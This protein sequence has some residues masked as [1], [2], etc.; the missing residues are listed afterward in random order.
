MD[1]FIDELVD[2]DELKWLNWCRLHLHVT[3]LS[4]LTTADGRSLTAAALRGEPSGH[5]KEA[6]NWPRTRR[7]GPSHWALWRS[8]L[9]QAVLRPYS[10]RR[11]LL[12]P[13]GQ[14]TDSLDRWNWLLSRTESILFHRTSDTWELFRPINARS[15]RTFRKGPHQ[16][17]T[18]ALPNDVQRTS[19]ELHPRTGYVTVTGTGTSPTSN[20]GILHIWRDLAEE[21]DDDFGWVP[22]Y[23]SIEG[24]E[25]VLLDALEKGKLRMVSD[26]SFKQQVG[27]AAVQLRTRRGGH[28]IWIKCRTPGKREDQSAYR[29]E[30]IGLLAGILVTSWLRLRLQT[31]KKPRVRVACDGIA[32]L[33]RASLLGRCPQPPPTLISCLPFAKLSGCLTSPGRSNTSMVTPTFA[34]LGPRCLGGKDGIPRSTRSPKDTP[35][36]SWQRTTCWLPTQ[37]SFPN[38]VRSTFPMKRCPAWRWN[39]ST[40]RWSYPT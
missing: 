19:V 5:F 17:W 8:I 13:L 26:G 21:M 28:T 12:Q 25:Q 2:Q 31:I 24:D 32:A 23:I 15:N 7:P 20:C 9:S 38:R 3:T 1:I 11:L 6:Y 40:R 30:L 37:S 35:T 18:G 36:N 10:R 14:W 29:S 22:E 4:E 27:T 33:R 39:R 34:R 16:S